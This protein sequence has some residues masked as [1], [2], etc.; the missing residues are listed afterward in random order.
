MP[1]VGP[2][3]ATTATTVRREP[4]TPPRESSPFSG[5]REAAPAADRFGELLTKNPRPATGA[6]PTIRSA[7]QP[8]I[9][10]RPF[11][12]S[13]SRASGDSLVEAEDREGKEQTLRTVGDAAHFILV[14]FTLA[15]AG[16]IDWKI[17]ASALERA[18][19]TGTEVNTVHATKAV[20]ALL[21]T[22]KLIRR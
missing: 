1:R 21:E 11:F 12:D 6:G 7:S 18:A 15:R 8:A 13:Y 2:A 9:V 16:D 5:D 20:I 3:T 19:E 10:Q 17:A 4:E 14:N 22:E